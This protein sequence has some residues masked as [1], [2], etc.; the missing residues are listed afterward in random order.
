[1][2]SSPFLRNELKSGAFDP[3]EVSLKIAERSPGWLGPAPPIRGA[4][5]RSCRI[6]PLDRI[7]S[8]GGGPVRRLHVA[9]PF[10]RLVV[11]LLLRHGEARQTPLG[12]RNRRRHGQEQ[13]GHQRHRHELGLPREAPRDDG[14]P[15]ER[16]DPGGRVVDERGD[17]RRPVRTAAPF[18]RRRDAILETVSAIRETGDVSPRKAQ[19]EA[20]QG[21]AEKP[22]A[23]QSTGQ[24]EARGAEHLSQHQGHEREERPR[25]QTAQSIELRASQ[26][27][28]PADFR[29]QPLQ[30][31]RVGHGH[32]HT[33][34]DYLRNTSFCAP[35]AVCTSSIS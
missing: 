24:G 15:R 14:P 25:K 23:Q 34:A 19:E 11:V 31:D 28:L 30:D 12:Q 35:L 17:H 21:A 22:G 5:E 13:T 27:D 9:S 3:S 2:R 8:R 33:S 4:R 10:A 32:L 16:A 20:V 26:A 18:E 29:D 6:R 7:A 1:M